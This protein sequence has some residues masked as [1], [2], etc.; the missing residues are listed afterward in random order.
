MG[1][2]KFWLSRYNTS[3]ID[4][5]VKRVHSGIVDVFRDDDP[6]ATDAAREYRRLES[7]GALHTALLSKTLPLQ[8]KTQVEK[9]GK[10]DN[11]SHNDEKSTATSSG[12]NTKLQ[13]SIENCVKSAQIGSPLNI[14]K[15]DLGSLAKLVTEN[16]CKN[17]TQEKTMSRDYRECAPG[18]KAENI[19]QL[20]FLEKDIELVK[21]GESCLIRCKICKEFLDSSSTSC[22]ILAGKIRGSL[23]K[24]LDLKKTLPLHEEGH[25]ESWFRLK[26]RAISHLYSRENKTHVDALTWWHQTRS[27]RK[28]EKRVVENLELKRFLLAPL[29]N[30]GMPPHVYITADKSTNHWLQNQITV[31]VA[32]VEGKRKPIPLSPKPVYTNA[33]GT[34]GNATELA[35]KIYEDIEEHTGISK[36]SEQLLQI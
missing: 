10:H 6:Q 31:I 21:E 29:P 35:E 20:L 11:E 8:K 13:S 25:N 24:G 3:T 23:S 18:S 28:Q 26:N 7:T 2:T 27:V 12:S 22:N 16:V 9:I 36:D 14:T 17:L 19:N 34:G 1:R 33:E 30:T 15:T 4:T 32:V 5:H